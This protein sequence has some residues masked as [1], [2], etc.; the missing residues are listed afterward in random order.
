MDHRLNLQAKT[1]QKKTFLTLGQAK[2]S[3]TGTQKILITEEKIDI[4]VSKL[5]NFTYQGNKKAK[6]IVGE[7]ILKM[8]I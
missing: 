5:K 4:W 3:Q 1:M 6:Q 7:N 8:C 2:I